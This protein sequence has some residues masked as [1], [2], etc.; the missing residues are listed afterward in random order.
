MTDRPESTIDPAAPT[1]PPRAEQPTL[2]PA[3]VPPS[4][5]MAVVPGYEIVRE[6]GRGGMGVVYEA[7][8]IGLNRQVALK[9]ILAGAHASAAE[10]DRFRTEAEAIARLLHPNIVQV[11][12][13]GKQAGLPYFSLEFCPGGS[14]DRKLDGTP[15]EPA[16]AAALIETL[17]RAIQHAHEHRIVHR[18]I[19]PGNVLLAADGTPKV[20]DF[21]LVKQ[22]D[23]TRGRTQGATLGTPSYMAPE[24]AGTGPP[25][26]PAADVY[27]LG[28]VLYE[29]LTGR[30]PFKGATEFDTIMQVVE[31][32]PVSPTRLNPKT[33][34]D[35][36]TVALKCLAKD[37]AKRYPSAAALAEDVRRFRANEPILARPAGAI[38]K[39]VKWAKRRPTVAMLSTAVVLSVAGGF[40]GVL[41]EL[42]VA[43]E[44][45]GMAIQRA[46]DLAKEQTRLRREL[47]QGDLLR[48]DLFLQAKDFA[49]AEPSLWRTHFT[50]PDDDDRRAYW[51]LWDL[52]RQRPRRAWWIWPFG[53]CV[54]SPDGSRAAVIR[55]SKVTI[56]DAATGALLTKEFDT[57]QSD[58][59]TTAFSRDGNRLGLV[60]SA[61]GSITIW[62]LGSVAKR[63]AR[64]QVTAP[65]EMDP[66]L[67]RGVVKKI[68]EEQRRAFFRAIRLNFFDGDRVLITDLY[69]ATVWK[70]DGPTRTA[71]AK[72][73]GLIGLYGARLLPALGGDTVADLRAGAIQL[74]GLPQTVGGE[75]TRTG[76]DFTN[77]D[78]FRRVPAG[79]ER[80]PLEAAPGDRAKKILSAALSPDGKWLITYGNGR[81]RAWDVGSG[82]RRG[83]MQDDAPSDFGVS[84][85]V[86]PDSTTLELVHS[87]SIR[88]FSLPELKPV[89]TVQRLHMEPVRHVYDFA[90]SPDGRQT[91]VYEEN[92]INVYDHESPQIVRPIAPPDPAAWSLSSTDLASSGP[93]ISLDQK[94]TGISVLDKGRTYTILAGRTEFSGQRETAATIAPTGLCAIS[95][96][97]GSLGTTLTV[98]DLTTRQ[99]AG[100][101]MDLRH[102]EKG[103]VRRP[104][105][106]AITGDGR[107]LVVQTEHGLLMADLSAC[108]VV[109]ALDNAR[110]LSRR[111]LFSPDGRTTLTDWAG[112]LGLMNLADGA[113]FA[114]AGAEGMEIPVGYSPDGAFMVSVTGRKLFIRDGATLAPVGEI[115]ASLSE[116][117]TGAIAPD[118]RLV[119]TGG[120]DGHLRLWDVKRREE[121]I[122]IDLGGGPIKKLVFTPD[123]WKVRFIAEKQMGEL[124]LHAYELYVEG[125]LTWNLLRLLPKLDRA[126]AERVLNRLRDSHPEA[127]RAGTAALNSGATDSRSK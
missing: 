111:P 97:S 26:G 88:V 79:L 36:E 28:A 52:Y 31:Q 71:E 84:L 41:Y 89:C 45:R 67:T 43:K 8:Q 20:T 58:L 108:K 29:L 90:V 83:D 119:A 61:D 18:D 92:A 101:S 91:Y 117:G 55:H 13:T 80:L 102:P 72:L 126:D 39:A 127:Y 81:F 38:E 34:R 11:Y 73:E 105:A 23:N 7:R 85:A 50:R 5:V 54:L 12:E 3:P 2:T 93:V 33:P 68:N 49:R 121:L 62:D 46:E 107:T 76:L 114:H 30:P 120:P 1:L 15:W 25:V 32:E 4:P 27:A 19:K 44:A 16:P 51:R 94:G 22:L 64:L 9:M 75:I 6:L 77:P 57:G 60:S 96:R 17:A 70:L 47:H 122:A 37:P 99:I 95:W 118:G 86:A 98:Y 116:L 87:D 53:R 110:P 63:R 56:H 74:W 59:G 65:T 10:F 35:L 100:M 104:S 123:G 113:V 115:P 14:L 66:S 125:N 78:G 21:G 103:A 24:Q 42:R 106:L 109:R 48:A 82:A 112:M 40:A 124:D 69:T